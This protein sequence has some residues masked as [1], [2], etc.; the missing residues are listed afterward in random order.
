M[1]QPIHSN[2]KRILEHYDIHLD[3]SGDTYILDYKIDGEI[4]VI[5]REN[6]RHAIREIIKE[7]G[8]RG[9]ATHLI[10]NLKFLKLNPKKQLYFSEAFMLDTRVIKEKEIS[11]GTLE[12]AYESACRTRWTPENIKDYRATRRKAYLCIQ[13]FGCNTPPADVTSRKLVDYVAH[14]R[15]KGLSNATINRNLSKIRVVLKHAVLLDFTDKVPIFPWTRETNA[16]TRILTIKEEENILEFFQKRGKFDFVDFISLAID[17]GARVSELLSLKWKDYNEDKSSIFIKSS[18]NQT[19]R[20]IPLVKRSRQVLERKALKREDS[21]LNQPI[22]KITQSSLSWH[23]KV[24]KNS[25]G[26]G[27]SQEFVP[28]M[29]RHTC[30]TRLAE[31]DVSVQKIMLWLG[32]KTPAMSARYTHMTANSLF[33]VVKTLDATKQRRQIKTRR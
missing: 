10:N 28:H 19:S 21:D 5:T 25:L 4:K 27:S 12:E 18:K 9:N 31:N 13:Y 3:K 26:F 2:V 20:T 1:K 30:A 24:M 29:M 15:A 6:P 11:K 7:R 32:H 16:R 33:G 8:E 14:L 17:T 23:W 22:F